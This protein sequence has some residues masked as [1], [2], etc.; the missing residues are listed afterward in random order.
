M[1]KFPRCQSWIDELTID[2]NE[3]LKSVHIY[4]LVSEANKVKEL[5][6]NDLTEDEEL[7]YT[8]GM[9]ADEMFAITKIMD[10]IPRRSRDPMFV[11]QDITNSS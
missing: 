9:T 2:I 5:G 3:E 1:K 6:P 8:D 4:K 7:E 10:K 11:F